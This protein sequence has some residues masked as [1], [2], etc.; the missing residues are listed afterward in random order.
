MCRKSAQGT[1]LYVKKVHIEPSPMLFFSTENRPLCRFGFL[2][3]A[4]GFT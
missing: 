3:Y 2:A 4:Y 1:V